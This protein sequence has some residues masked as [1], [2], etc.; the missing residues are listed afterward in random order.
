MHTRLECHSQRQP[1]QSHDPA[2]EAADEE[3]FRDVIDA[4][5][6]VDLRESDD[7]LGGDDSSS[8]GQLT[9]RPRPRISSRSIG[10]SSLPPLSLSD[11]CGSPT[12]LTAPTEPSSN[13]TN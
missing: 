1:A 7:A 13:R 10:P 3:V 9:A 12:G 6:C 11:G 4:D 2:G 8:R 5:M